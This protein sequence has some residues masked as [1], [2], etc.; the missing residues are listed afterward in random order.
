MA[1]N[2]ASAQKTKPTGRDMKRPSKKKKRVRHKTVHIRTSMRGWKKTMIYVNSGLACA[3]TGLIISI[4][5]LLSTPLPKIISLPV[6][7][8]SAKA[9]PAVKIMPERLLYPLSEYDFIASHNPFS[10][11]RKDWLVKTSDSGRPVKIPVSMALASSGSTR[12]VPFDKITLYGTLILADK[13]KALISHP[14]P[15]VGQKPFVIVQEGEEIGG[16]LVKSIEE[17]QIILERGGQE[18]VAKLV[19]DK[20]VG[21]LG[22]VRPSAVD[23]MG[24]PSSTAGKTTNVDSMGQPSST[25]GKTTKPEAKPEDR[26]AAY[27]QL[28]ELDSL[29]EEGK[30]SQEEYEQQELELLKKLK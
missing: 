1:M 4:A 30:I 27:N 21:Q 9:S 14:A 12:S 8:G 3:C 7:T 18:F 16:Y 6:G 17:K 5:I 11:N 22:T 26:E 24:Q 20:L 10:P 2:K 13:K 25:A 29:L 23:S 15:A 28:F 19:S